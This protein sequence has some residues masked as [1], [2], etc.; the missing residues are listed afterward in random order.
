MK[1][2]V[3]HP[4]QD[5]ARA[6]HLDTK[7]EKRLRSA[8]SKAYNNAPADAKGNVSFDDFIGIVAPYI[9]TPEESFFAAITMFSEIEAGK[10]QYYSPR[11]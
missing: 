9:H 8:I 4:K 2:T 1:Y 10:A 6:L 3:N 7:A 11:N 5:F